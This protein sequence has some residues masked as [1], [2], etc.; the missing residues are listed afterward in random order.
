M[1]PPPITQILQEPHETNPVPQHVMVFDHNGTPVLVQG[2]QHGRPERTIGLELLLS[3]GRQERLEL[4]IRLD[5]IVLKDVGIELQVEKG[6]RG[7]FSKLPV[8]CVPFNSVQP[9]H[10][11]M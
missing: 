4:I 2:D 1:D 3:P 11:G 8:N 5:S 10:P 7:P 6:K 9:V